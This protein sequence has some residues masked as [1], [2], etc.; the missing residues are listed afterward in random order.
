LTKGACSMFGAWGK[1]IPSS[2]SLLQLRGL[3]WDMDGPFR[4][5]PQ[6]TIYHPDD[7]HPFANVGYAGF[8][9][10]FS[11]M[12]SV[13]SATSEI[14]VSYHDDSFGEESRFGIPFTYLLRDLLQFDNSLTDSMNRITNANRTCDLILGVGDGNMAQF[15]GVEYSASVANFYDDTNMQPNATWHPIIENTVYYGMDWNCPN[16]DTVFA[17]QLNVLWG[18][19]TAENGILNITSIIQSGDNFCS[20]YDL[21]PSHPTMW[22]AFASAAGTE[23]PANAYDRTFAKLDMLK[24]F[25]LSAPTP[26][27]IEATKNVVWHNDRTGKTA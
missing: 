18:N 14:G 5:Y 25:A 24:L 20:Y 1:S 16:Y 13:P 4:N 17:Q 27:Q 11:G 21:T 8:I 2:M 6:V 26:E 23:G 12:S 9:G 7:G 19:I 3:D 15:R 10:S 22:V